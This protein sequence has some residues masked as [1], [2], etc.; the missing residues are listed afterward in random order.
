MLSIARSAAALAP[1]NKNAGSAD[2]NRRPPLPVELNGVSV[3]IN[4][5][6]AG[7]YFVSAG[8]IRFVV[9]V[10]LAATTGTNTY[11]VVINNNGNLI[12]STI[13]ILAAQ[14]DIFTSTSDAGGRANA[15]NITNSTPGTP[16]PFTVTTVNLSGQTVP[17][18]LQFT[19]TG[20]RNVTPS[21]VTVRIGTTDITGASILAVT[22]TTTPGMET[23]NVQLPASLA[24]AGDVPVIIS[25][26]INSVTY[27]S[28]PAESAPRIQIQ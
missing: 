23:I 3:S 26:T 14:P 25:V 19:V 1:S 8:E 9:P 17:T 24:G 6:A 27:T 11:P 18:I 22:P 7:L 20:V 16:E 28:R 13:T 2:E 5:A 12:R 4:G 10:G 21:Q 15:T